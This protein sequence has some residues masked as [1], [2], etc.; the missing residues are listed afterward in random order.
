MMPAAPAKAIS[1]AMPST[2]AAARRLAPI[3]GTPNST[4]GSR[5]TASPMTP[6]S[7]HG[8]GQCA[9]RGRQ[10]ANA[11]ANTAPN[12]HSSM[13]SFSRLSGR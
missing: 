9:L 10:D 8:S 7:P 11:A 5:K 2:M 3:I 1:A 12:S 4:I 13:R 6:P